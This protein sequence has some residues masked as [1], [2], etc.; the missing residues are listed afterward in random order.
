MRTLV[1]NPHHGKYVGET[2]QA[3]E[4]LSDGSRICAKTI[5]FREL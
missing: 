2:V 1:N 3:Q 5:F 4:R